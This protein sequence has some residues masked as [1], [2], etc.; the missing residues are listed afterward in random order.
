MSTPQERLRRQTGEAGRATQAEIDRRAS[1]P[2]A[3]GDLFVLPQT[4]EHFV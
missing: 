2:P 1:H 3:A 4:A